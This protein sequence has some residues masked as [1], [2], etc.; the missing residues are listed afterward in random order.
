MLCLGIPGATA[1]DVPG[2]RSFA[3]AMG[4]PR[5]ANLSTTARDS[6]S[7]DYLA[8]PTSGRYGVQEVELSAMPY[9]HQGTRIRGNRS[10]QRK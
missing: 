7:S 5:S 1:F 4:E 3:V 10:A 6:T 9:E 8:P 2:S